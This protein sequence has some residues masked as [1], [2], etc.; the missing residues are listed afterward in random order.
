MVSPDHLFSHIYLD[1]DCI[2]FRTLVFPWLFI[3]PFEHHHVRQSSTF[4][5]FEI[6]PPQLYLSF[7]RKFFVFYSVENGNVF[8]SKFHVCKWATASKC[9]STVTTLPHCKDGS[10]EI[11]CG[12]NKITTYFKVILANGNT[13]LVLNRYERVCNVC[14]Y[15]CMFACI[16]VYM[17]V[18]MCVYM[19]VCMHVYL[20]VCMYVC[21][22][23]YLFVCMYVCMYFLYNS[24]AKFIF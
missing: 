24:L 23:V 17:N 12:M 21:M 14:M 16:Y 1:I 4:S 13:K 9:H 2:I 18:C 19:Y 15:V 8:F 5:I 3:D 11:D 20:Y 10:D 7:H 22:H 6:E